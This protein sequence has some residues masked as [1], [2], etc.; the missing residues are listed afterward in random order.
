MT[1]QQKWAIVGA[2][3]VAAIGVFLSALRGRYQHLEPGAD[4]SPAKFDT[5]T[6]VTYIYGV[7]GWKPVFADFT[8]SNSSTG[9]RLNRTDF[10]PNGK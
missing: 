7:E 3:W 6:G 2:I 10:Y 9:R 5:W 8:G 1:K 4:F